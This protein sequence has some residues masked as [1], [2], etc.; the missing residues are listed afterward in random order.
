[1]P[2]MENGFKT[3][4]TFPT[5]PAIKFQEKEVQPFGVE[6]GDEIDVS[7]MR[8]TTVKTK[9]PQALLD[10][11]NGNIT[12]AYEGAVLAQIIALVNVNQLIVITLPTGHG[13]WSFWGY[14][15]NFIPGANV[16][17]EQPEAEAEFVCTNRNA[18]GVET[19]PVH[20][21]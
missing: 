7:T 2:V 17:G 10:F 3:L 11:T 9:A 13:T 8:N 5:H 18:S 1:M 14:L 21:P 20:T 6:G 15:K 19:V 16:P 4:I 12:V